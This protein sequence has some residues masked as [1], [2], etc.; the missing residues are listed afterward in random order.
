MTNATNHDD[1]ARIDLSELL[2]V[3]YWAKALGVTEAQLREA[4]SQAR[5][6][7]VCR[8]RECLRARGLI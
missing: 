6:S 1:H 5:S 3:R 2:E 4:A 8:V 7:E